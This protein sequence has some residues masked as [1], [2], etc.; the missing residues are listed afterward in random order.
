MVVLN[1]DLRH[2]NIALLAR[3]GW[4]IISKTFSL[5]AR[6]L[7][8]KYFHN[9]SFMLADEGSHL[10]WGWKSILASREILVQGLR[11]QIGT[12]QQVLAFHDN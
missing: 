2:F 4:K 3:Q 1:R 12:G 9:S 7:K 6:V 8:G 11:C 5:L 10:S